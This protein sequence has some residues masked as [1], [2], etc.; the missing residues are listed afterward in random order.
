MCMRAINTRLCVAYMADAYYGGYEHYNAPGNT[1]TRMM[2]SNEYTGVWNDIDRWYDRQR[3]YEMSADDILEM[4]NVW[5]SSGFTHS[6]GH[7]ITG[8]ELMA[9]KQRWDNAGWT[10]YEKRR[11][12][13]RQMAQKFGPLALVALTGI[14]LPMDG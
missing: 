6:D 13:R 14:S 2:E 7:K 10:R 5:R 11:N 12:G 8:L 4:F 9:A 3:M 1:L